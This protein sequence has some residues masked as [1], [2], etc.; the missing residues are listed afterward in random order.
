MQNASD[1]ECGPVTWHPH[2]Q[3][4]AACGLNTLRLIALGLIKAIGI[5]TIAEH[6]CTLVALAAEGLHRKAGFQVVSDLHLVQRSA[7]VVFTGSPE[8]V[9]Y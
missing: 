7:L 6:D 9:Q 1:P 4:Y 3:Q 5:D 2:G 8:C